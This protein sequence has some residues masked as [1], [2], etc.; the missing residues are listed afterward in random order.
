M[1]FPIEVRFRDMETSPAL[2]EFVRRWAGKLGRVHERIVSCAVVIERPHQSQHHGQHIHVRISLA[3]PG[4]D[5]VVS[6]GQERD[7]AHEDAYVAVR[8]AFRAA[9]RQ[10]EDHVRRL[11]GS[12]AEAPRI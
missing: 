11:R 6:H 10:L 12:E 9:R 8:D 1:S 5:I 3:V 2:E 4:P 7:G